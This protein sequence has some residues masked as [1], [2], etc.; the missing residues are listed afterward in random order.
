MASFSDY[1]Q[2]H[3]LSVK[4]YLSSGRQMDLCVTFTEV[5]G[6]HLHIYKDN[7]SP[8]SLQVSNV[9][10]KV[11]RNNIRKILPILNVFFTMTIITLAVVES[12]IELVE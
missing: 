2:V 1:N 5:A 8:A 6:G 12:V 7:G 10:T 11:M 9:L 3:E 4:A